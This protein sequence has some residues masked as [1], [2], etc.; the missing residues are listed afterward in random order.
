MLVYMILLVDVKQCLSYILV[1]IP[2]LVPVLRDLL[3]H[4]CM[5]TNFFFF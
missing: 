5:E 1:H 4:I 3:L 2:E